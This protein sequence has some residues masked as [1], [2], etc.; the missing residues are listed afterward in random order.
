MTFRARA[1]HLRSSKRTGPVLYMLP[2]TSVERDR[3]VSAHNHTSTV[4]AQSLAATVEVWF[5]DFVCSSRAQGRRGYHVRVEYCSFQSV[6]LPDTRLATASL[7]EA[8]TRNT[9]RTTA[10]GRRFAR[11]RSLDRNTQQDR[12]CVSRMCP[13]VPDALRAR[14]GTHRRAM[15]RDG[16]IEQFW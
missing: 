4:T 7:L 16:R 9:A 5:P 1:R 8:L 14:T 2:A 11:M 12:T 3:P 6:Q 13:A 15:R 10:F